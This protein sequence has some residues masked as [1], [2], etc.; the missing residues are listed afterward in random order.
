MTSFKLVADMQPRQL[1]VT[2][3]LTLTLSPYRINP[4]SHNPKLSFGY[5]LVLGT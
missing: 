5:L 2:Q 1:T 3:T 4:A